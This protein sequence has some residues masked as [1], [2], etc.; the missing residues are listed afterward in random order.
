MKNLAALLWATMLA[1]PAL[2][3]DDYETIDTRPRM[4]L[5]PAEGACFAIV[6][7]DNLYGAYNEDEQLQTA[8]GTIVL[9]Y[10]TVGDHAPGDDDEVSVVDLP[11]GVRAEPMELTIPDGDS[12]YVCLL[13]YLGL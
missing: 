10:T 2:A 6:K 3:Y 1:M 13:E 5:L 7:I 12:G 8:H 9:R 11:T 4:N